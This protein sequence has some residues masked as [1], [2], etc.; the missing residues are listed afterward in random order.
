MTAVEIK[1]TSTVAKQCSSNSQT[2]L[3][4]F[5]L[6]VGGVLGNHALGKA[7]TRLWLLG[8]GQ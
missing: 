4:T 1:R 7:L 8:L 5:A 3:P 6:V 2:V